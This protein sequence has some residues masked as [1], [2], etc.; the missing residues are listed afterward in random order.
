MVKTPDDAAASTVDEPQRRK[1]AKVIE[2]SAAE[3]SVAR[4][5]V[6]AALMV[7][8][9]LGPGLL[10]SVYEQCLACELEA[11]GLSVKRQVVVPVNYRS[12][13]IDAGFRMGL[14]INQSIVVEIKANEKIVPVHKAQLLTY[15]KLSGHRLGLLMNFN[16]PRLREG[17]HRVVLTST[18]LRLCDFAVPQAGRSMAGRQEAQRSQSYKEFA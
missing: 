14:V 15:L 12:V 1:D 10:E 3:N 7:H 17:L 5:I 4:Q 6:D 18:P 9:T 2:P 11:R 8:S 16:V 13:K